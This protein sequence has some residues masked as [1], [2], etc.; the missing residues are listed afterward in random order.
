MNTVYTKLNAHNK[1]FK[2]MF[3]SQGKYYW[4][5]GAGNVPDTGR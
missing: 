5:F 4:S 3:I 2:A 1:F